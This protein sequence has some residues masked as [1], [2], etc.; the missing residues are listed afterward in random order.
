MLHSPAAE[1]VV[2]SVAQVVG[3]AIVMRGLWIP[4]NQ[5]Q[6]LDVERVVHRSSWDL[7]FFGNGFG[8]HVKN[9]LAHPLVHHAAHF[10]AQ[11][12]RR[13]VNR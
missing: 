10:L 4:R 5:C 8:L 12:L 2:D 13:E 1:A 11:L 3:V 6:C 9:G 7:D